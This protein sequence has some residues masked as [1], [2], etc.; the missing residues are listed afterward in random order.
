LHELT[1]SAEDST[2]A[3]GSATVTIAFFGTNTAPTC[4]ILSPKDG[5]VYEQGT[6]VLFQG[7]ISDFEDGCPGPT[8]TWSSDIDGEFDAQ[9]IPDLG[10]IELNIDSDSD[11]V[12]CTGART[13]HATL[14]FSSPGQSTRQSAQQPTPATADA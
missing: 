1:L 13:L 2:G 7:N 10:E 8:V 5:T 11:T 4:A 14:A 6:A 9:S 12:T 3:T